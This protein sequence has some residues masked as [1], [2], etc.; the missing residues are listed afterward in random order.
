MN[1]MDKTRRYSSFRME[2]KVISPSEAAKNLRKTLSFGKESRGRSYSPNRSSFKTPRQL[3]GNSG[4]PDSK[5]SSYSSLVSNDID[6]YQGQVF[7][8][9]RQ[10]LDLQQELREAQRALAKEIRE[11]DGLM[12]ELKKAQAGMENQGERSASI[13]LE[14]KHLE[15]EIR[16]LEESKENKERENAS[17]TTDLR[18]L[19][20]DYKCLEARF[21]EK[22]DQLNE[23]LQEAGKVP[24]L[25]AD[26]EDKDLTESA[27]RRNRKKAGELEVKLEKAERSIAD[28]K[29]SLAKA[30][31]HVD[32]LKG[33]LE[34]AQ[35]HIDTLRGTV[36]DQ[37]THLEDIDGKYHEFNYCSRQLTSLLKDVNET[38][39]VPFS[40][41]TAI[42]ITSDAL[43]PLWKQLKSLLEH[44]DTL[45]IRVHS[46]SKT[47]DQMTDLKFKE[48]QLEKKVSEYQDLAFTEEARRKSTE[49]KLR[50]TEC[51][52]SNVIEDLNQMESFIGALGLALHSMKRLPD[53]EEDM[54][55]LE[56]RWPPKLT[57]ILAAMNAL[58]RSWKNWEEQSSRLYARLHT[59]ER[60]AEEERQEAAETCEALV[61]QTEKSLR[62]LEKRCACKAVRSMTKGTLPTKKTLA[63][64][65]SLSGKYSPVRSSTGCDH[66]RSGY[67]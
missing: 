20:A 67:F 50:K 54:K 13:K 31:N 42:D 65:K 39:D 55:R 24:K 5:S 16:I 51:K 4:S 8:K 15:K 29:A 41:V 45:N 22:Q 52:Y 37:T 47:A 46:L 3:W 56:D 44:F 23:A 61:A 12:W 49:S 48:Q 33:N 63:R 30:H 59:A 14:V 2:P 25:V 66:C 9:Q 53:L 19:Q 17:L 36:L 57:L 34:N 62:A 64:S 7:E 40:K 58:I 38:Q 43:M 6:S 21:Q 28:L 60:R 11:K 35:K 18:L 10:V 1:D 27:L 26:L 32:T